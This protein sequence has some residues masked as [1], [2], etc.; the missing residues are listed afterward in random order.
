MVKFEQAFKNAVTDA[1]REVLVAQIRSHPEMTISELGKL[2]VGELGGLLKQ[3]TVGDL[4]EGA[5]ASK[6]PSPRRSAKAGGGGA[7]A[8][9]KSGKV[10][11]RTQKGRD[12]YDQAILDILKSKSEPVSAPEIK[13]VVGGTS[14]QIRTALNRLISQ[15]HVTYTGKARGTRYQGV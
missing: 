9:A 3:I 6:S 13:N 7:K 14:L 11:T 10:N 5:S 2:S 15:G 4:L 8:P 1:K 12:A